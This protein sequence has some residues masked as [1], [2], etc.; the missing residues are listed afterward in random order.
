MPYNPRTDENK[1]LTLR[2]WTDL[3]KEELE[4]HCKQWENSNKF[5]KQSH[6]WPEWFQSFH[7]YMS[8]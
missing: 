4:T 5:H 2:Q 8:W 3:A 6:T 7:Y 1:P